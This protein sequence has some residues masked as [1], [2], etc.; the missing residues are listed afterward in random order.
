MAQADLGRA[1]T[2]EKAHRFHGPVPVSRQSHCLSH[3]PTTPRGLGI[4][5]S[6]Y[7]LAASAAR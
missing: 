1:I 2:T 5:T 3:S 6:L 7:F 4:L